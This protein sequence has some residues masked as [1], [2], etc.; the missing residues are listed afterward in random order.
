[1]T[2]QSLPI[3]RRGVVS[4]DAVALAS[5]L[6]F[7]ALFAW[8]FINFGLPP[9]EDAAMLMRYADHFAHGEGIVWNVGDHP[10]DGATDFL[11]MVVVAAVRRLGLSIDSA[12]R[13]VVVAAHFA[14]IAVIYLGMRRVQRSGV[15]AASL[16]A[17]FFALGPGLFIGAAYFGA[18]FFALTVAIAWL[19]AQ[20]LM[21]AAEQSIRDCVIFS[22]ASLIAGL[23]R[24]EGVLVSLMML[25]G[26]GVVIPR[27][28]FI[29][30]IVVFAAVFLALGGAYFIWRWSYFGYPLPNPYYKKGDGHLYIGGLI[31]S[32]GENRQ[33]FYI[34]I[35][36]LLLALRSKQ[37]TRLGL[38]FAIPIAGSILMWVALSDEMD[39]AGRFQYPTLTMAILSWYPLV[40]TLPVDFHLPRFSSLTERQR[41]AVIGTAAFVCLPFVLQGVSEEMRQGAHTTSEQYA[42]A[43]MLG[44]Y[45]DRHYTMA[46]TEAGILPL[47]SH[48]RAIDTWGLNDEWIAHHDG[49]ITEQYLAEQH[50]DLIMFHA[51]FSPL[52]PAAPDKER[53]PWFGPWMRQDVIL[54][55][56]AEKHHFILAAVYGLA[57]DDTHY[58]YVSPDL[59]E[60][61][62]IVAGIRGADECAIAVKC[63]N[64][65][66]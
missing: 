4:G 13:F 40:A 2:N 33:T 61:N 19:R 28:R 50:P 46:T 23:V 26:I 41:N 7:G 55:R 21:S 3:S 18:P 30:L 37:A 52:H 1:V 58:Y 54:Q 22:I 51:Y 62:A 5:V 48:W 36:A 63:V 57:A 56:Y 10:V 66:K 6:A 64:Y 53:G 38:A 45:A 60:T 39:F 32:V 31:N 17:L 15:I 35:P 34:F 42:I 12:T 16:S 47:Y 27:R 11:F 59:P 44:R 25:A 20:Q 9:A 8:Q 29:R 49:A 14:T 43:E 65:A 24:P